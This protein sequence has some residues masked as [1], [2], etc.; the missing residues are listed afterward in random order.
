MEIDW[1]VVASFNIAIFCNNKRSKSVCYYKILYEKKIV[2]IAGYIEFLKS[3]MD[4]WRINRQYTNS[5]VH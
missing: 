1:H 4:V 3:L 2:N 5:E